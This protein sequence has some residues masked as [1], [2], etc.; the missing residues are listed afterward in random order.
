MVALADTVSFVNN[1]YRTVHSSVLLWNRPVG[2]D[3]S[4]GAS[5]ELIDSYLQQLLPALGGAGGDSTS[6]RRHDAVCQDLKTVMLSQLT[7]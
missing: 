5:L 2:P 6:G 1:N 3:S 7:Q 4:S